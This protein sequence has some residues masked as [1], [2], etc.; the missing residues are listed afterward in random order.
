MVGE[1]SSHASPL[2]CL[3]R[4][5]HRTTISARHFQT[6]PNVLLPRGR[7]PRR[8][9]SGRAPLRRLQLYLNSAPAWA[10]NSRITRAAVA[11]GAGPYV[12]RGPRPHSHHTFSS[13]DLGQAWRDGSEAACEG[14]YAEQAPVRGGGA[15]QRH[16]CECRRMPRSCRP[17]PA[18]SAHDHAVTI[19]AVEAHHPEDSAAEGEV[20]VRLARPAA[21][22]PVLTRGC[23]RQAPP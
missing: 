1:F 4:L 10:S 11:A 2:S 22:M 16:R 5:A 12:T 3:A 14:P 18:D 15:E 7:K 6:F 23:Q 17:A 8:L 9:G 20:D 13:P 19:A 21:R